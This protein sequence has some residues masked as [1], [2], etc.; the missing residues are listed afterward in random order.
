M[1][2]STWK[3]QGL[4]RCASIVSA[5]DPLNLGVRTISAPAVLPQSAQF[6]G[7]STSSSAHDLRTRTLTFMISAL[8]TT[9]SKSRA[10]A[11][12]SLEPNP[13]V[14]DPDV[15]EHEIVAVLPKQS[16]PQAHVNIMVTTDSD[17]EEDYSLRSKDPQPP[18]PAK[19]LVTQPTSDS[20][21]SPTPTADCLTPETLKTSD[22]LLKYLN[23]HRHASFP[24]HVLSALQSLTPEEVSR[25]V[26]QNNL[27]ISIG[28][29]GEQNLIAEILHSIDVDSVKAEYPYF[30]KQWQTASQAIYDGG[31]AWEFH[32]LLVYTLTL[33]KR[34]VACLISA[35]ELPASIPKVSVRIAT[36]IGALESLVA[37]KMKVAMKKGVSNPPVPNEDFDGDQNDIDLEMNIEQATSPSRMVQQALWLVVSY[38]QAMEVVTNRR[39]LPKFPLSLT[40]LEPPTKRSITE[41]ESWTDVIHSM[42]PSTTTPSTQPSSQQAITAQ[43]AINALTILST[44]YKGKLTLF[45]GHQ[46]LFH[47]AYHAESML[48]TLSYLSYH[49]HCVTHDQDTLLMRPTEE[50]LLFK[51]TCDNWGLEE[52]STQPG[53]DSGDHGWIWQSGHASFTPARA[54]SLEFS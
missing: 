26:C 12:T 34:Y 14:S 17:S 3:Y 54:K 1:K 39:T 19:Y 41:M 48:G 20:P 52:M 8:N 40:F 42:Y 35:Q 22:S 5:S 11:F 24:I 33:A 31:S 43:E 25:S 50:E 21:D 6:E 37:E 46:H 44:R 18:P 28:S 7:R 29:E 36:H 30:Y 16:G 53:A 10:A 4:G 47:G 9:N 45:A 51:N 13:V 32:K 15:R 2:C 38:Q 27:T 49:P 23:S